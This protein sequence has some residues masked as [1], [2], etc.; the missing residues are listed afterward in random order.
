MKYT[1]KHNSNNSSDAKVYSIQEITKKI[2]TT[3]ERGFPSI[4]LEG[5]VSNFKCTAAGHNYFTLKDETTQISAVMFR[6]IASKYEKNSIYSGSKIKVF[7]NISVYERSGGYQIICSKVEQAG[8]GD[9]QRKFLELKERLHKEGWFEKSCK[10]EIPF[11]SEKIAIITSKTGAAIRDMLNIIYTRMDN[12]G[13][14]VYPVKVQG[15]GAA[16]DIVEAI[17]QINKTKSA[18]VIITGRG[19][20]SI[21]DLWAFNE[22]I[23]AKAI[24][25]SIIPVISAVGHEIDFTISDFV[26][27][28]RA[29][30]PSAAAVM[31]VPL[32]EDILKKLTDARWSLHKSIIYKVDSLKK[33][34]SNYKNHYCFKDS[35]N[36]VNQLSQRLDELTL[37][38]KKTAVTLINVKLE[39]VKRLKEVLTSLSPFNILSRGYSITTLLSGETL[40]QSDQV[41]LN[42]QIKT[43]FHKGSLISKV[44]HFEKEAKTTENNA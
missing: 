13:V 31:A 37:N 26:A 28:A 12:A 33:S 38:I 15:S 24:K 20:G 22:Y 19:G 11:F 27:D 5:E 35:F 39:N 36:R 4:W 8:L 34:V 29:E 16:K 18:E 2:K 3:L 40:T 10:K 17:K 44:I 6:S 23:V 9:L 32:K 14:I 41:P 30:T 21:E 25:E 1:L 7:G 43:I 42:S